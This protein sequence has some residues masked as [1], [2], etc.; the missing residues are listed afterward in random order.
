MP[1]AEEFEDLIIWQQARTQV[2]TIYDLLGKCP[3]YAYRDQIQRAAVSVMNNIAEG[4]ERDTRPD[5]I[6]FLSIAN[7]SCGE[8]RS[9]LYV[10]EDRELICLEAAQAARTT[11]KQLSRSIKA[12]SKSLR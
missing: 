5:F 7:G 4:F 8:V 2:N 10:A 9:M 3:D 1:L 11:A 6:R 12:F